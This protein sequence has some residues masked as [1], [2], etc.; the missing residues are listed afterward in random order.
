VSSCSEFASSEHGL[1]YLHRFKKNYHEIIFFSK[2]IID[3]QANILILYIATKGKFKYFLLINCQSLSTFNVHGRSNKQCLTRLECMEGQVKVKPQET[4]A[5]ILSSLY[6]RYM[7][8]DWYPFKTIYLKIQ[9]LFIK[10]L[11]R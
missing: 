10:R 9:M 6:L 4:R 8:V 3:L 2:I 7:Y 11:A 5:K 1:C